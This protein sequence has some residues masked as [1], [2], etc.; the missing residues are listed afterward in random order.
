MKAEKVV[1]SEIMKYIK[2]MGWYCIKVIKG[3]EN[4][5]HDLIACIDGKFVS[6]EVKA[7]RY[8]NNPA[9]QMSEWQKRHMK[10]VRNANGISM[11]VAT[12]EQFIDVLDFCWLDDEFLS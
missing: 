4:G 7:E 11:C 5:I 3:N 8:H 1:Q 6:I 12:L 10:L 2:S 9:N